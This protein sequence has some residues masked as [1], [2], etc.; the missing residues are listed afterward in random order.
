MLCYNPTVLGP[1]YSTY[2]YGL[3]ILCGTVSLFFTFYSLVAFILKRRKFK[4]NQHNIESKLKVI[5]KQLRITVTM[6]CIA[7]FDFTMVVLPLSLTYDQFSAVFKKFGIY[8][9]LS[10]FFKG[11]IQFGCLFSV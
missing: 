2:N 3:A 4:C 10:H 6:S 7:F 8:F 1:A 9:K 5:N 11:G